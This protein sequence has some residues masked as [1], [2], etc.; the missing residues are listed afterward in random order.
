[1]KSTKGFPFQASSPLEEQCC[2]GRFGQVNK[3]TNR[4]IAIFIYKQLKNQILYLK[5][6]SL[7]SNS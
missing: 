6:F 3:Y 5:K 1:M 4:L 7:V 2:S